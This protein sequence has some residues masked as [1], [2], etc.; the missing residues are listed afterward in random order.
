MTAELRDSKRSCSTKKGYRMNNLLSKSCTHEDFVIP[1]AK[2]KM[3]GKND[4]QV[5]D[6]GIRG[7]YSS[8]GLIFMMGEIIPF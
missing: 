2:E 1:K 7:V 5:T 3:T 6:I 4:M 8:V